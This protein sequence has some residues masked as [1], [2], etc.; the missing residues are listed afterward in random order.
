VIDEASQIEIGQYLP[1]FEFFGDNLRKL[2]FIGDEQQCAVFSLPPVA[3]SLILHLYIVPPHGYDNLKDLRSIFDLDHLQAS[4]I[5]LNTQCENLSSL[6][7]Y[8]LTH[9]YSRNSKTVCPL[10]LGILYLNES[11][12]VGSSRILAIPSSPAPPRAISW[13]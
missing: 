6:G 7:V 9:S 1:L 4:A 2:C 5:F 8:L 13:I 3:P 10:K 11:T 12:K